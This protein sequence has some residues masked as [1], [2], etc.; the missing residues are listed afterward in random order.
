MKSSVTE[1]TLPETENMDIDDTH[2]SF[3]CEEPME[4]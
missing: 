3:I 1:E 2:T 4:D